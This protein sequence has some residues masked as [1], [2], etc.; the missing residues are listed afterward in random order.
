MIDQLLIERNIQRMTDCWHQ[1]KV[2]RQS[3]YLIKNVF[4]EAAL[5]KL[6]AYVDNPE[7]VW[8][9]VEMQEHLPRGKITWDA[10]TI[11]EELHLMCQGLDPLISKFSGLDLNF[12]GIQI[13]RDT[14]GYNILPHRDRS[15]IDIAMQVYLFDAPSKCGTTFE[16]EGDDFTNQTV[17]FQV[18]HEHNCG[19][20]NFNS[21]L[22]VL[23]YS[24][25]PVPAG[26]LRYSLYAH[27]SR[28]VK[29]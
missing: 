14:E 24:T 27:W 26:V 8:T 10:D 16:F 4:T 5:E 7:R 23:H 11:I 21:R 22:N 9:Q 20:I 15:Q 1:A 25:T 17:N 18:P 6:K 29:K 2:M 3:L 19:Y 28:D 12:H 13:W